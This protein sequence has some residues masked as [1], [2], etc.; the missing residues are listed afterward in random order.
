MHAARPDPNMDQRGDEERG[1][2]HA[3]AWNFVLV[4]PAR[5]PE[6]QERGDGETDASHGHNSTP[7]E[8]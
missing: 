6:Q 2:Q 1:R 5:R 8:I 4:N 7:S 3:D